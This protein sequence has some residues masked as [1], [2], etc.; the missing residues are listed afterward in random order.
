MRSTIFKALPAEEWQRA[1]SV[2][3]YG[4]EEKGV[5]FH[6]STLSKHLNRLITV[7]TNLKALS[8]SITLTQKIIT[9]RRLDE[10]K[11]PM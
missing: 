2:R 10:E 6:V 7:L 11:L 1:S 5:W 8:D 3:Q 4:M 9:T